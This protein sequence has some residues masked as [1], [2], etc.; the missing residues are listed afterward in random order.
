MSLKK[1][2]DISASF[3]Q[4]IVNCG[5]R[6]YEE[7]VI[8]VKKSQRSSVFIEKEGSFFCVNAYLFVQSRNNCSTSLS[9]NRL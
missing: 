3:D 8:I 9:R 5:Q 4:Y 1:G 7:K 2:D 6:L